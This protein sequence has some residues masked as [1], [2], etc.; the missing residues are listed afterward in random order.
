MSDWKVLINGRWVDAS[1]GAS[2]F[3]KKKIKEM[4]EKEKLDRTELNFLLTWAE[5]FGYKKLKKF[6]EM[7][8]EQLNN[9][10]NSNG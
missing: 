9:Q 4:L 1:K 8:K 5:R 2:E 10:L 3:R 7:K 6:C